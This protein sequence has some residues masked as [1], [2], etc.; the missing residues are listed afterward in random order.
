MLPVPRLAG[1]LGMSSSGAGRL[2]DQLEGAG[3][4]TWELDGGSGQE[5]ALALTPAGQ[6]LAAWIRDQRR[7][8]LT[9]GLE[10]MS[11]EDRQALIRGLAELAAALS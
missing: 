5:I 8:D 9:R 3:L 10:S 2:C 4:G 1:A 11:P 7:A 6:R